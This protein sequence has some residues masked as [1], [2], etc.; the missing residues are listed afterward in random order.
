MI[1]SRRRFYVSD[2]HTYVH[3]LAVQIN[4]LGL[5]RLGR[6]LLSLECLRAVASRQGGGG[7]F[8]I[9]IKYC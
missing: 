2:V 5:R 4:V 9:H 8:A 7:V 6:P 1:I 3:L